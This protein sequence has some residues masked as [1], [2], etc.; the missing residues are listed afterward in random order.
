MKHLYER[1]SDAI[2]HLLSGAG[3]RTNFM[4]EF[5]VWKAGMGFLGRVKFGKLLLLY[6]DV[7]EPV[8]KE[9]AVYRLGREGEV[10]VG[11]YL[12]RRVGKEG[13]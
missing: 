2:P 7:L 5:M 8:E 12:I 3:N 6:L 4:D 9:E 11:P 1:R 13:R 10:E